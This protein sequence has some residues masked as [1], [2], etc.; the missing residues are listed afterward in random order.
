V[1]H[2]PVAEL[3]KTAWP[4]AKVL[5]TIVKNAAPKKKPARFKNR[6]PLLRKFVG[7]MSEGQSIY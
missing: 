7:S 1:L 3:L 6:P 5:I 4:E 2:V